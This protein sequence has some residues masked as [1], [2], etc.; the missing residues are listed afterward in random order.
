MPVLA[1]ALLYFAVVFAFGF[2]FGV[3]RTL[4]AV[5][6]VGT[7]VAELA[8][9]PLMLVVI[10]VTARALVTRRR[11]PGSA[12]AWLATGVLALGFLLAAEAALVRP[13]R[14]LTLAEWW[15]AR[16]PVAGLAYAAALVALALAPWLA[17]RARR[18][19]GAAAGP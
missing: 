2:A 3:V 18:H 16:D 6:L 4:W 9:M 8:E 17:F 12:P 5:P 10:F 11:V 14:G 13:L 19:R 15:A 7:R 1:T